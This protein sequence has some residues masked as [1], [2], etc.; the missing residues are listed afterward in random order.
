VQGA[1]GG[2][3]PAPAAVASMA[4]AA[5]PKNV[6]AR[7]LDGQQ[8]SHAE[9]HLPPIIKAQLRN[10]GTPDARFTGKVC[11]DTTGKVYSVQV[12]SGIPGADNDIV[13]II[14]TWTYKPQPISVCFVAN[15]SYQISD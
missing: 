2:G 11:V 7:T 8:I 3:K 6:N 10:A 9:P 12:L 15:V 14:K 1:A 13:S 5:K 4:P